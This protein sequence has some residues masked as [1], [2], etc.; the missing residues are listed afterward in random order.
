MVP[1]VDLSPYDVTK[2][3]SVS[4]RSPDVCGQVKHPVRTPY[5]HLRPSVHLRLT[6]SL[7]CAAARYPWYLSDFKDGL[8]GAVL[9]SAFFIFFAALAGAITFGGLMSKHTG[10]TYSESRVYCQ[11]DLICN[12]YS[13]C[14]MFIGFSCLFLVGVGNLLMQYLVLFCYIEISHPI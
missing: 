2:L 5:P 12:R 13:L 1:D 4:L 8:N 10:I 9:S 11:R 6:P 14:T 7:T 3:T